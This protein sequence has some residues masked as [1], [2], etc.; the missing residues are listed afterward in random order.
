[1]IGQFRKNLLLNHLAK[2]IEIWYE[3]PIKG[4]VKSFLSVKFCIIQKLTNKEQELPMVAI[5]VYGL[6]QNEQ[7]L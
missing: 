7:S 6:G 3:A 5:F 1:V 2:I 4:S